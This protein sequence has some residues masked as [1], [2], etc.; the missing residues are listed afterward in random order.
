MGGAASNPKTGDAD[1]KTPPDMMGVMGT[2]V[3]TV[4]EAGSSQAAA[5]AAAKEA[6]ASALEQGLSAVSSVNAAARIANK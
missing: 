2:R 1:G 5:D 6:K 3:V 4:A